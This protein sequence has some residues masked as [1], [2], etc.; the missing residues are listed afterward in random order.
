VEAQNDSEQHAYDV[1]DLVAVVRKV[2]VTTRSRT[3]NVELASRAE[4][5]GSVVFESGKPFTSKD[6]FKKLHF[7]EEPHEHRSPV[8]MGNVNPQDEIVSLCTTAKVQIERADPA[9][10]GPHRSDWAKEDLICKLAVEPRLVVLVLP[11]DILA[12]Q[13]PLPLDR[14]VRAIRERLTEGKH[15]GRVNCITQ[16]AAR[17]EDVRRCLMQHRPKL[18]HFCGHGTANGGVCMP[19]VER[20]E[21]IASL[22]RIL[23][24]R[25]R[26]VVLS[27]CFSLILAEL[28][29]EHV[30]WVVGIPKEIS[31]TAAEAFAEAFYEAIGDNQPVPAA[32]NLGLAAIDPPKKGGSDP[33]PKLVEGAGGNACKVGLFSVL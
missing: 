17:L 16:P 7:S 28:L 13:P 1:Q 27:F 6:V 3:A 22:F 11:A 8:R 4:P 14:E 19:V 15:G 33:L 10:K 20:P 9:M 25:T 24:G 30:D 23:G 2:R 5:T 31:E 18:V 29:K 21:S 26:C 12:V 32:F